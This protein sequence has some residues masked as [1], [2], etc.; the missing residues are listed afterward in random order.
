[1]QHVLKSLSLQVQQAQQQ[2]QQQAQ[3]EPLQSLSVQVSPSLASEMWS[4]C[5]LP[6]AP[7]Q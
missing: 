1:M 6:C 7:Q 3:Q 4:C 2:Q 5:A